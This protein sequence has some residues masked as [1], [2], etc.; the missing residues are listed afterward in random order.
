[1][2]VFSTRTENEKRLQKR[3]K[4]L[5]AELVSSAGK[6]GAAL[7]ISEADQVTIAALRREIEKAWKVV[8]DSQDKACHLVLTATDQSALMLT[9]ARG[10]SHAARWLRAC[11]GALYGTKPTVNAVT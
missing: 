5:N 6:V 10:R 8:K 3:F 1:M 7:K 9:Y 11:L 2:R 4:E